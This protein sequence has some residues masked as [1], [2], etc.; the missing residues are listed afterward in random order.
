[1]MS[2]RETRRRNLFS[3]LRLAE[4]AEVSTRTIVDLE[5]GR[6]VPRLQTIRKISDALEVAPDQI[7]EF[8]AALYE[9]DLEEGKLA[10]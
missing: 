1:M 7:A 9:E 6:T 3:I 2:L 4:K 5:H 10:A 8:R